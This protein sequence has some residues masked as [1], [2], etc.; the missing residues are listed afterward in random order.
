[1]A[2]V[3]TVGSRNGNRHPQSASTKLRRLSNSCIIARLVEG[4]QVGTIQRHRS[5][6]GERVMIKPKLISALLFVAAASVMSSASAISVELAK[7]CEALTNKAFPPRVVGNPAAGS[8]K[9]SGKDA[10]A[11]F[12]KCIKNGGKVDDAGPKDGK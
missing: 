8:A 5:M 10:Q 4:C 6:R 1:M 9:G 7:K 12:D 3:M 11:F 2:Q